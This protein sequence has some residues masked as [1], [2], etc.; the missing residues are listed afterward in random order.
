MTAFLPTRPS[1][2]IVVNGSLGSARTHQA[3]RAS[4][5]HTWCEVVAAASPTFQ[6]ICHALYLVTRQ[7]PSPCSQ[8]RA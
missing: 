2:K 7:S 4:A 3:F 1:T 5:L 6:E 8:N